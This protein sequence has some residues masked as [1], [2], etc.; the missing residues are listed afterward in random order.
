MSRTWKTAVVAGTIGIASLGGGALALTPA[1]A[2]DAAGTEQGTSRLDRLQEALA[3][4]VTDSTIT[5]AQADAVA[6][7]L[8]EQLPRGGH[9]P[10]HGRH[11][12]RGGHVSL[13]AAA[14]AIGI[15]VDGL[16]TAL[17]AGRTLTEVAQDNGVER[18]ALVDALVADAEQ[19][20]AAAVED[21]K[22]TQEQADGRK[23][24]LRTRIEEHVDRDLQGRG[25][26]PRGHYP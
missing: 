21:G 14:T 7:R 1:A 19:R 16:R 26:G 9:G 12:G 13:D 11:G 25:P 22:L 18:S 20:L 8:D 3:G 17:E 4:L 23:A 24:D 10:G 2:Q 6:Q 15:S 5:Q